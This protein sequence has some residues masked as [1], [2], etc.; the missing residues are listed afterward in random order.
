[1]HARLCIF[2]VIKKS[3]LLNNLQIQKYNALGQNPCFLPEE[4]IKL[5]PFVSRL[6]T[7]ISILFWTNPCQACT[8]CCKYQRTKSQQM[9]VYMWTQHH[10]WV[11]H[12]IWQYNLRLKKL[13]PV[14]SFSAC[15]YST[16]LWIPFS[17][18]SQWAVKKLHRVKIF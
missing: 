1:M 16:Q 9:R 13:A 2:I 18:I 11:F 15:L 7:L 10:F 3:L 6:K 14:N 17:F 4:P 8:V 12:K 5:H